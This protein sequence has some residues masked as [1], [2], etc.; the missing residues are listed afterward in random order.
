M[1]KT[2]VAKMVNYHKHAGVLSNGKLKSHPVSVIH[3][4]KHAQDYH[5]INIDRTVTSTTNKPKTIILPLV[6]N[7]II[8]DMDKVKLGLKLQ[9][10]RKEGRRKRIAKIKFDY[11]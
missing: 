4:D 8:L 9:L 2:L 7:Y 11:K 5:N 1:T 3:K 10:S 6:D